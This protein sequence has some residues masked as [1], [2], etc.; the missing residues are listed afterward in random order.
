MQ[1]L[2]NIEL[3]NQ[4]IRKIKRQSLTKYE[5]TVAIQKEAIPVSDWDLFL[6]IYWGK[7][8]K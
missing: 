4:K 7:N 1:Q 5:F 2:L 8:G 6:E 3:L